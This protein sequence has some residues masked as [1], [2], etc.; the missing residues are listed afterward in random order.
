MSVMAKKKDPPVDQ[1]GKPRQVVFMTLDDE[2]WAAL[3]T[4]RA[5][6]D[7]PPERAAVC[8]KSLRAFLVDREYLP[9]PAP[10]R[11]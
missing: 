3:E 2:T 6:Q 4:Y 8:L 10:R 1:S 5:D 9:K 7:V 11:P